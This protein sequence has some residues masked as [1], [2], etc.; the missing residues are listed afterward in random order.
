MKRGVCIYFSCGLILLAQT[1]K[2]HNG[3]VCGVV[4]ACISQGGRSYEPMHWTELDQFH[5][6][7]PV[8]RLFIGNT[9][10]V[11]V[12]LINSDLGIKEMK[13][14]SKNDFLLQQKYSEN[15]TPPESY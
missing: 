14:K 11:C 10:Y 5:A 2:N 9:F 13:L 8:K 1:A 12:I 15:A 3:S 6:L 4:D 7:V